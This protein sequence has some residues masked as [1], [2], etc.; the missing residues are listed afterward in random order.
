M[1]RVWENSRQKAKI[2]HCFGASTETPKV[3][4]PV[5]GVAAAEEEKEVTLSV[6]VLMLSDRLR[7]RL[8]TFLH[9]AATWTWWNDDRSSLSSCPS[10][11]RSI[12]SSSSSSVGANAV[13]E[14]VPPLHPG[15]L[16]KIGDCGHSSFQ[17]NRSMPQRIVPQ[18]LHAP[19]SSN[20]AET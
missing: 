2:S 1:A 14:R 9:L 17:Q 19:V 3:L 20:E 7:T 6:S 12:L 11:Y 8:H 13:L 10:S 5:A 18:F 16:K 15:S 4:S